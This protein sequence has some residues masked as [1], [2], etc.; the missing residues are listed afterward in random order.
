[1]HVRFYVHA[2]YFLST[3]LCIV[4]EIDVSKQRRNMN[5]STTLNKKTMISRETFIAG[6]A[7]L[8]I[9]VVMITGCSSAKSK[10]VGAWSGSASIGVAQASVTLNLKS[11]GTGTY[12]TT[13]GVL[14]INSNQSGKLTW[15]LKDN[16]CVITDDEGKSMTF[17]LSEDGSTMMDTSSGL[18][19]TKN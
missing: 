13:G 14:G 6:I 1:M 16:T 18:T 9:A 2:K 10:V 12:S 5:T 15:E 7:A 19:L 3:N 8:F 11:D 4:Q 17:Q